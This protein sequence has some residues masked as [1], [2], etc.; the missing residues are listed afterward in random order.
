MEPVRATVSD[1][2]TWQ[3]QHVAE[4]EVEQG[5]GPG[6]GGGGDP[7]V[8]LPLVL[9]G[10]PELPSDSQNSVDGQVRSTRV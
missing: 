8:L 3:L 9:H 4:W 7:L 2:R 6:D 10:G 5:V 1:G